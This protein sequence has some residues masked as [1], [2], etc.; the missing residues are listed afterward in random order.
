[1]SNE[2]SSA[3]STCRAFVII[4]FV[5]LVGAFLLVIGMSEHPSIGMR[6]HISTAAPARN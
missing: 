6:R 2:D 5:I 3:N 4:V 1:M